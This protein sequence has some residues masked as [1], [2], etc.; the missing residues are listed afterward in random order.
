MNLKKFVVFLPT[1]FS[2]NSRTGLKSCLLTTFD[3]FSMII[4]F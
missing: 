1:N 3:G 2:K 4:S